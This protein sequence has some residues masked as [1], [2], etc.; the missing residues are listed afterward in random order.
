[1]LFLLLPQPQLYVMTTPQDPLLERS[2]TSSSSIYAQSPGSELDTP[3]LEKD[4]Q[5]LQQ[6]APD[7]AIEAVRKYTARVTLSTM[8]E[9]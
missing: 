5:Q 7:P 9:N 1:M 2:Y 6:Q 4:I 3:L 8:A